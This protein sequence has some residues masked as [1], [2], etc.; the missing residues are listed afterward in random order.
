MLTTTQHIEES[1]LPLE[2][3]GTAAELA[4]CSRRSTAQS[5]R[6][7]SELQSRQTFYTIR[8]GPLVAKDSPSMPG[9]ESATLGEAGNYSFD[10]RSWSWPRNAAG[11][12]IK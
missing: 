1:W 2:P 4:R 10:V 5:K 6:E 8:T 9:A 3:T 11:A 12:R 7:E